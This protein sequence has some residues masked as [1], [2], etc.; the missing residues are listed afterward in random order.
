MVIKMV[1]CPKHKIEML[2]LYYCPK[3]GRNFQ[4]LVKEAFGKLLDEKLKEHGL[5][6]K[7]LVELF[8]EILKEGK[9]RRDEESN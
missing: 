3:C 1:V 2:R 9:K 7:D 4:E 6:K 5:E 8:V